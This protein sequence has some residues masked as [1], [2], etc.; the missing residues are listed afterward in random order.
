MC[1]H[2]HPH[3]DM[4]THTLTHTDMQVLSG[5][6]ALGRTARKNDFDGPILGPKEA[7]RNERDFSSEV[8]QE[9]NR[10]TSLQ[11]GSN[12]G[13]SSAGMTPYG[14]NRQVYDPAV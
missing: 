6:I 11:Y 7:E 8:I 14:L 5:I 9:G 3:T 13:A 2:A 1:H 4:H 12:K 10:V